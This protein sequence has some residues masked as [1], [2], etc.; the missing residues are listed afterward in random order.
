MSTETITRPD[1]MAPWKKNK[2]ATEKTVKRGLSCFL[3]VNRIPLRSW[4]RDAIIRIE[5]NSHEITFHDT[6]ERGEE[7]VVL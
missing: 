2:I 1:R 6:G 4:M 7:Y 5:I 3:T